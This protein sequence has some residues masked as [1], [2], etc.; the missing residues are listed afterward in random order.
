MWS[1]PPLEFYSSAEYSEVITLSS[2]NFSVSYKVCRP[3]D[4]ETKGRMFFYRRRTVVLRHRTSYTPASQ[5]EEIY[6][7]LRQEKIKAIPKDELM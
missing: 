7:Q 5:E 6:S 3:L 4:N 2:E 1:P